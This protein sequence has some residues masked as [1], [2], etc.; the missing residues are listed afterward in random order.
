MRE[1][2]NIRQQSILPV[3]LYYLYNGMF[4]LSLTT[5]HILDPSG[6]QVVLRG[7]ARPTLEWSPVGEHLSLADYQLIKNWGSNVVRIGLS[8]CMCSL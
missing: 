2:L 3:N 5:P 4:M 7:V 8:Q 6:N 1:L